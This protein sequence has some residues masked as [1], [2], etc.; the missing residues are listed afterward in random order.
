MHFE[1][2]LAEVI[3]SYF[4]NF[5]LS[6]QIEPRHIK[7]IDFDRPKLGTN[8]QRNELAAMPAKRCKIFQPLEEDKSAFLL[9]SSK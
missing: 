9:D 8:V 6:F 3:Y 7:D 1:E 4:P 2:R 5:Y